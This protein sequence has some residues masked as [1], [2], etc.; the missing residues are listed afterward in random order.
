MS[1]RILHLDLVE[2]GEMTKLMGCLR[3]NLHPQNH[4]HLKMHLISFTVAYI[5]RTSTAVKIKASLPP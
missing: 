2:L 4:I 5:H 1:E 3:Y